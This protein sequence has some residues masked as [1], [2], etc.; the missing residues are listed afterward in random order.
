M[1]KGFFALMLVAASFAGGALVNGPGLR[2]AQAMLLTRPV[3][4]DGVVTLSHD[5]LVPSPASE[6]PPP[7]PIP[8]VPVPPLTVPPASPTAAK[9][10]TEGVAEPAKVE[11]P[12]LQGHAKTPVPPEPKVGSRLPL[13]VYRAR[14]HWLL[15]GPLLPVPPPATKSHKPWD[16]AKAIAW[17]A[18][19]AIAARTRTGEAIW[20][21]T[22]LPAIHLAAV[23]AMAL[24]RLRWQIELLF[25]RLK[26]LL[27]LDSMQKGQPSRALPQNLRCKTTK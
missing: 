20:I 6:S 7:E 24:Y 18:A 1:R 15:P 22:T 26:S 14:A 3:E 16:S 17:L 13:G 4:G 25:K 10:K 21:L 8:S 19:R 9:E 12:E 5:D 11:T 2:W 27:H 23:D